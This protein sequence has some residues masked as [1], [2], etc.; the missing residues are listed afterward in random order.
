MKTLRKFPST[1]NLFILILSSLTVLS[2]FYINLSSNLTAFG[3]LF[4][5]NYN[6][7][8]LAFLSQVPYPTLGEMFVFSMY[9]IFCLAIIDVILSLIMFIPSIQRNSFM[10]ILYKTFLMFYGII[11]IMLA[12]FGIAFLVF[13]LVTHGF[14]ANNLSPIIMFAGYL[15]LI[16]IV[17][18]IFKTTAYNKFKRPNKKI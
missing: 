6:Q 18:C 13:Y 1:I 7:F 2:F 10:A 16:P 17:Q 3:L 8:Q 15:T 4:G 14:N 12:S 11:L 5:K 9:F